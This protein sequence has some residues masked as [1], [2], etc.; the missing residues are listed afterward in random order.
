MYIKI[1]SKAKLDV[2]IVIKVCWNGYNL[3]N[4]SYLCDKTSNR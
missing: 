3:A 1:E 2:F 4:Y